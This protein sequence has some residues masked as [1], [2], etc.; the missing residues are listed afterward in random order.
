MRVRVRVHGVVQGVGFRA[1]T[2]ERARAL[3][4]PGRVRDPPG[5]SVATHP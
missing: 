2:L 5:G 1:R 3:G 4:A